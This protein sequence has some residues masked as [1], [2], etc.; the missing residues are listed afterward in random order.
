VSSIPIRVVLV[1]DNV[2]FRS[3]LAPLL[4][5][6]ADIDV[7]GV[8]GNGEEAVVVA[9]DLLPDVVVMDIQMPVQDG[10][11]ATRV[12]LAKWPAMRVILLTALVTDD[13][14]HD[15]NASGAFVCLTKHVTIG[16]LAAAIREAAASGRSAQKRPGHRS[17]ARRSEPRGSRVTGMEL[18]ILGMMAKGYRCQRIAKELRLQPKTV[19]NYLTVIY[20]KLG[21]QGRT[22]AIL[23]AAH[24]G[25]V[26]EARHEHPLKSA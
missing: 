3:G 26:A 6:E 22:S 21:V 4:S 1:D 24:I 23:Y 7:V 9:G 2:L 8:A 18:E 20:E 13:W 19:S 17:N 16:E 10:I 14:R 15:P 5:T 12:M 11:S 25:L